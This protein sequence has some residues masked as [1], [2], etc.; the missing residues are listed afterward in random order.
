MGVGDAVP[1][2]A[3]A[4]GSAR[5]PS[6]HCAPTNPRRGLRPA[7][8]GP[9]R[10]GGPGGGRGGSSPLDGAGHRLRGGAATRPVHG[11][12]RRVGRRPSRR[13]D[14][15][16]DRAHRGVRGGAGADRHPSRGGRAAPGLGDGR[17]HPPGHGRIPRRAAHRVHPPPGDHRLHR[18]HRGGDRHAPAQGL[19]RAAAGRQPRA[20]PRPG[21]RAAPGRA[22]PP[23]GRAV[24]RARH[25]GAAGALAEGDQRPDPRRAGR[26]RLGGAGHRGSLSLDAGVPGRDHRLALR[27]D[28]RHPARVRLA[29]DPVRARSGAAPPRPRDHPDAGPQRL[30]DRAARRHRVAALRG[31]VRRDD[32]HPARPGRGAARARGGEPRRAV[33]RGIRRHRRHRRAPR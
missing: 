27:R 7:R 3:R 32:R 12:R 20:L 21:R 4:A 11:H 10:A 26:A 19:P 24:H 8:P 1:L 6:G 29:M 14:D 28:P 5:T 9:R 22:H 17:P 33:L 16:G 13:V 15:P 23:P 18:G 30:R 2:D 31:G 25:P